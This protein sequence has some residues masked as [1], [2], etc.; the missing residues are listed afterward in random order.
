MCGI[1][2]FI[3]TQPL[4]EGLTVAAHMA[5]AMHHRGPDDAGVWVNDSG[6]AHLAH[7]RLAIVDLSPLGHQPMASPSGRY[8]MAFNG[9]VYNFPKLRQELE[10]LGCVFRGHSDTEVLVNG[11]E[12]WGLE[13]TLQKSAGMFAIALWDNKHNT[14]TLARDRMG[15][16]PLYFGW[17]GKG[18]GPK[19][20]VFAS[21]LKAI[22][23]HPDF[24]G[25][26]NRDALSL[27]MR[28]NAIPAP[29]SI[30]KNIYKLPAAT[31]LE[32]SLSDIESGQFFGSMMTEKQ[33]RYWDFDRVVSEGRANRLQ[34]SDSE[35]IDQLD[36]VL[37]ES[38]S[39]KMVADVPLGAFL[40]GGYD[41]TAVVALMQSLSD[42]PVHTFSIGFHEKGYNE[43]EH[44]KAVAQ[45]L[46]TE[47]TEMYVTPEQALA[48][49]PKLPSIYDEPFSDSS[50]IPM[51]LVSE[52]TKQHVTVAL[53]GDGGDE[54]FGGYNRYTFGNGLWNKLS[55]VPAP[56]RQ[57]LA[58]GV[59]AVPP[60]WLDALLLPAMKLLPQK[61]QLASPGDKLHK[62]AS[63]LGLKDSNQLYL[64]LL[65]HWDQP[66]NLVLHSNEPEN[67]F[68]PRFDPVDD[69][70]EKMMAIDTVHYMADDILTKVDRA[71]MAVS[72]ESR[73]PL[74]D[75]RVVEFAWQ[76][77]FNCKIRNGEGKWILKHLIDRYVPRS[78]MERPKMGFGVP[79]DQWLR[80][81]LREWAEDLLK[82]EK[83]RQQGYFNEPMVTEKWQEHLSGARNWQYYLWDVLMF[84]AWLREQ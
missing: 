47:H 81:E 58:L 13:K 22:K 31:T 55:K 51:F 52:M 23:Q 64:K 28:H 4:S 41:S 66:E 26:I 15:E 70:V 34:A 19:G 7:A 63:I 42:K 59:Q 76:L 68:F 12:H 9:E 10:L 60:K 36:S 65:S 8:M 2:G 46:G 18:S 39:E 79:I 84:Q 44:A 78:I 73:V 5:S 6:Q 54:L 24:K 83:L 69:F 67:A 16:K 56:L 72:L 14:L 30:Y 77:P 48:V 25:E 82:P 21:E 27:M 50:Q 37:K 53:S 38:I 1:A 49:I 40:S 11:M 35:L 57:G 32:V 71:S 45:H 62:L 75:H 61:Y 80:S 17:V 43:A 29:H 33:S 3:Q 74:I 20:L